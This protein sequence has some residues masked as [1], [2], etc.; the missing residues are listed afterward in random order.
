MGVYNWA[1]LDA[2]LES[3]AKTGA[4]VLAAIAIKPKVLYPKIDQAIW[5]P[6][7]VKEWQ[8]LIGR[9]GESR[10]SGGSENCDALE[11]RQ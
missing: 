11:C 7:N 1:K 10:Y 2:F 8:K 5:R 4:T 3:M 6:N 9:D